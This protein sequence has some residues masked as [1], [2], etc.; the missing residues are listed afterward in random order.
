M[1][2]ES[3]TQTPTDFWSELLLETDIDLPLQLQNI[4]EFNG[5]NSRTLIETF[6]TE[7]TLQNIET[8]MKESFD[9]VEEDDLPKLY[10]IY[11]SK[12]GRFQLLEGIIYHPPD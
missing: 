11:K 7:E 10:G 4:L 1:I 12:P 8:F 9:L 2:Q 3:S 5:F 6:T